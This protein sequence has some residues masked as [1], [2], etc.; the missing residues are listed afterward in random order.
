[1]EPDKDRK[2]WQTPPARRKLW[3]L[4]PAPHQPPISARL[5]SYEGE[6]MATCARRSVTTHLFI[7]AQCM[8]AC[9]DSPHRL[10]HI[11]T[12]RSGMPASLQV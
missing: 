12:T 9:V 11:L 5:A 10:Q 2:L 3:N 7:V 1:M 6:K 8:R 4:P